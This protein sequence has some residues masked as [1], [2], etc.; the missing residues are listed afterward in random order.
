MTS[1]FLGSLS[2]I[3]TG[4]LTGSILSTSL[5]S[6][7]SEGF[8]PD[9]NKDLW[10]NKFSNFSFLV[11]KSIQDE[12]DCEVFIPISDDEKF[13]VKENLTFEQ[14]LTFSEDNILDLIALGF[15]PGK[16]FIYEDFIEWAE[17]QE[18]LQ[19]ENAG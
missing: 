13:Y 9:L 12:F 19:S 7:Y 6:K 2:L 11:A 3:F 16:T 8:A 18:K 17:E 14:A 4:S 5:S 15:K 1:S 10:T